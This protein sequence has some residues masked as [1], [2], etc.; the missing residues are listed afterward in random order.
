MSRDAWVTP[1][2]QRLFETG[3]LSGLS[4]WQ[5]VERFARCRDQAAFE[6]LVSRHGPMVLGVCRRILRDSNDVD[7]AFQAT[8]LVLVRRAPSLGPTDVVAAWLHGVALKVARRAR[9]RRE[10]LNRRERSTDGVDPPSPAPPD[11]DFALRA[12]LDEEIDRLPWKYRAPVTLCYLQGLTHD[13][14]A[15]RLDWPIGTV[16]GRLARARTTL[17]ARLSRRGI[18]S[19]AGAVAGSLVFDASLQ[20]APSESLIAA[21]VRASTRIADGRAWDAV[22]S[23]SVAD[24]V[25]GV[26]TAMLLTKLKVVAVLSVMSAVTATGA[27]VFGRPQDETKKAE[28]AAPNPVFVKKAEP[29]P[30][31]QPQ[32]EQTEPAPPP[33]NAD[34]GPSPPKRAQPTDAADRL[35]EQLLVDAARVYQVAFDDYRHDRVPVERVYRASRFLLDA[36]LEAATTPDARSAAYEKH[37]KRI[38]ALG[39]ATMHAVVSSAKLRTTQDEVRAFQAEAGL[40]LAKS[41]ATEKG[42]S[43]GSTTP[44]AGG[45]RE[46][47]PAT[48][49]IL[50]KLEEP[51]PMSFHDDT[52]LEDVLRY[53]KQATQ[54]AN[55]QGVTIYVDPFGLQ[56]AEKTMTSPVSIDL[57]VVPLRR[58]LQLLLTQLGLCYYVDDGLLV[59]TSE[60]SEQLALPPSIKKPLSI[61]EQKLQA[62]RGEMDLDLMTNFVAKLKLI[63]ELKSLDA[64]DDGVPRDAAKSTSAPVVSDQVKA[65]FDQMKEVTAALKA[66]QELTDALKAAQD[67]IKSKGGFQ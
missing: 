61:E 20:A 55:D 39:T 63:K 1:Q 31:N 53:I 32:V 52:P 54:R 51:I 46:A 15:R 50:A 60:S 42:R 41:R 58:T 40:W 29:A 30:V 24:L 19:A 16:K 67:G 36:Q 27:G 37:L 14:A 26:F 2:L 33:F 7:D 49:E 64:P 23:T 9:S 25:R 43:S 13:E 22:V 5:L 66:A 45:D 38:F 18:T 3:S 21:A 35:Q 10:C 12:V 57:E 59:I 48:L 6:L 56:E 44:G 62:E 28:P 34:S 17:G 47:S 8:F 4:E 11:S 65:L